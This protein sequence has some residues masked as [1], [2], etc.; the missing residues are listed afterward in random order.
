MLTHPVSVSAMMDAADLS[1]GLQGPSDLAGPAPR[2]A[3]WGCQGFPQ[4]YGA[5]PAGGPGQALP[6]QA[7]HPGCPAAAAGCSCH[8]LMPKRALQGLQYYLSVS[9]SEVGK[10]M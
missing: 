7:L 2:D 5:C 3:H 4:R 9:T 10:L 6:A 8:T 1:T